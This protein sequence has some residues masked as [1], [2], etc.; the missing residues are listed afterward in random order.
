MSEKRQITLEEIVELLKEHHLLKEVWQKGKAH[1][2]LLDNE[3]YEQ[4]TYDSRQV[5]KNSLFICK[6]QNFKMDFLTMAQEKGA[7]AYLSE[8]HFP[9]MEAMTAILVTDVRKAMACVAMAFYGYPQKELKIIAY[10]GTKG[11]TTSAYFCKSILDEWTDHH[12]ALLSTMETILD[13]KTKQKSKLTTPESL[14]LYAMFREAV[15]HGMTHLVMEVSSQAYKLHRVYGLTFDIGIF[16]NLSPDHIGPIEHPTYEDY[17]YCKSELIENSRLMIIEDEI[18][19]KEFLLEKAAALHVPVITYGKTKA[20]DYEWKPKGSGIFS[21]ITHGSDVELSGD[22]QTQLLGDFNQ[23]NGLSALIACR[24]LGADEESLREGLRKA[25]VPGR[26]EC[27]KKEGEPIVYIDY[28]HNYLSASSLL[29]FIKK[30]YPQQKIYVVVG[31]TGNKAESRRQDFGRVLSE[32]ADYAV[33]TS[34]DPGYEDPREINAEIIAAMD[35]KVPYTEIVD[36]KEAIE[37]ILDKA[38][39]DDIVVLMGKGRDAS[40]QICGESVPYLGDVT[41]AKN[42]LGIESE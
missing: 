4:V 32:Y 25:L 38:T 8:T 14:D 6:G 26:M 3:T 21:V 24:Q 40:Q 35:S 19:Q 31:S 10:T 15:D 42:Y 2:Q 13:G 34:D 36:R 30:E 5:E 12:C 11:K 17:I 28:A 9:E 41:I 29:S 33:L 27:L 37:F 7:V 22:Y 18:D 1:F 20:A 23:S 16:L 39:K